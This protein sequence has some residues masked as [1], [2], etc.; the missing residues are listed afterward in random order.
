MITA[1]SVRL[2][3]GARA[4]RLKCSRPS[5]ADNFDDCDVNVGSSYLIDPLCRRR[6]WLTSRAPFASTPTCDPPDMIAV[7]DA[8]FAASI[9]SLALFIPSDIANELLQS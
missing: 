4:N 5:R 8:P 7:R 9:D 1:K 3:C 6:T 2:A